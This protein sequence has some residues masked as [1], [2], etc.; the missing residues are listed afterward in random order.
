MSFLLSAV[1]WAGIAAG[2][3]FQ[4]LAN[5]TSQQLTEHLF[6][7]K[8]NNSNTNVG[9]YIGEAYTVLIDPVVGKSNNEKLVNAIKKI[10]T[11]PIKYVLNTHS[12]R[13]H[14]GANSF[15]MELG[16]TII[17]NKNG[18]FHENNTRITTDKK[19]SL[20]LGTDTI[21]LYPFISHTAD[22][23]LIHFR[24]SNTIFMG[25]TYMHKTYPHAYV[26]GSKGQFSIINKALLLANESTNIVTAHGRL[27]AQKSELSSFKQKATLWYSKIAELSAQG[28]SVDAI[29]NN[30]ELK[31]ISK[32]FR[33]FSVGFFNQQVKKTI[34]AEQAMSK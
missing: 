10:T 23:V 27:T 2:N 17:S 4:Q 7:V 1:C 6:V 30:E 20:E 28:L 13:D 26:G 8:S 15:Y 16:A 21:D 24:N 29:L 34:K 3:S 18:I 31:E 22:D 19:H 9:V 12:H 25:D 33:P 5:F 11:K 14:T 32:K